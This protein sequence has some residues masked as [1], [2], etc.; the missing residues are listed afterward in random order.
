MEMAKTALSAKPVLTLTLSPANP[1]AD[2][3]FQK[4][5]SGHFNAWASE[6]LQT[7]HTELSRLEAEERDLKWSTGVIDEMEDR[8]SAAIQMSDRIEDLTG[9]KIERWRQ[10]FDALTGFF[11]N[12]VVLGEGVGNGSG[13]MAIG[14]GKGGDKTDKRGKKDKKSRSK[15]SSGR[16][17][18]DSN[19]VRRKFNWGEYYLSPLRI[20]ITVITSD[21]D[22]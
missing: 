14:D 2:A 1:L 18:R 6:T 4:T 8:I 11:M 13:K 21:S 9:K 16:K 17:R 19:G 12:K 15:E 5:R 7:L 10:G 3:I 22:S 20:V